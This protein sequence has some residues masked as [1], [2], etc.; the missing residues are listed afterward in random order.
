MPSFPRFLLWLPSAFIF[1]TG[2]LPAAPAWEV[3]P[4]PAWVDRIEPPLPELEKDGRFGEG[5]RY[6]LTDRQVLLSPEEAYSHLARQIVEPGGLSSGS[7]IRIDFDPAYEELLIHS[8]RVYR[9]GAWQSRLEGMD[10]LML[11]R[12]TEM[13]RQILDGSYTA[14]LSPRDIRTGDVLSYEYTLRG[15]NPVLGGKFSGRFWMGWSQPLDRLRLRF[16]VPDG[17]S[18]Q[19]KPSQPDLEPNVSSGKNGTEYA[20]DLADRP[21]ILREDG[22]PA[23]RTPYPFIEA[24]AYESWSGVVDW[25]L[26]LYQVEETLPPELQA[27][28]DMVAGEEDPAVRA[29]TILDWTRER[30]RYLGFL[31]GESSHRPKSTQ[32]TVE[33]GYGDCKAMALLVCSMLR[34]SGIEAAPVLVD[35]SGG[36]MVQQRI[37]SPGAFDHVIVEMKIGQRVYYVD[38]TDNR[39]RGPIEKRYL[40][41]FGYGLVVRSG[42][43]ALQRLTTPKES[44]PRLKVTERYTIPDFDGPGQL[45]VETMAYGGEADRLRSLF[46]HNSHEQIS[47]DYHEFQARNFPDIELLRSVE[48]EDFPEENRIRLVEHYRLPKPWGKGRSREDKEFEFYPREAHSWVPIEPGGSRTAHLEINHPVDNQ[49]T[50]VLE[51]PESWEIDPKPIEVENAV[52]SYRETGK[53]EGRTVT[54][55]HT[56]RSKAHEISPD[57]FAQ[58]R[59]DVRKVG[60]IIGYRFTPGLRG[61]EGILI[62]YVGLIGMTTAIGLGLVAWWLGRR[63][64]PLPPLSGQA[65]L[66]GIGGWLILVAIGTWLRPVAIVAITVQTWSQLGSGD[67][68]TQALREIMNAPKALLYQFI[69]M[70]ESFL[71]FFLLGLAIMAI[72]MLLLKSRWFPALTIFLIAT[73]AIWRIARQTIVPLTFQEMELGTNLA[74]IVGP[75]LHAA[76]WIPYLLLSK[77]VHATFR[78]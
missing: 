53:S 15:S 45:Q 59:R 28:V 25:A 69:L 6:L 8:V 56:Y 18:L 37:P 40:P 65:H 11:R 17:I 42:E 64:P 75:A 2:D 31:D 27:V 76:I 72:V 9:D 33:Q 62:Y 20:W 66:D 74:W 24:S 70:G 34:A 77:R 1:A 12:E 57:Q 32:F 67:T 4:V 10:V 19:I 52:F 47:A 71:L 49:L 14:T 68:S 54:F 39:Q 48:F 7:Q 51:L 21:G 5:V 16:L 63:Q 26:P 61:W 55:H 23:W 3:A 78:R 43:G 22:T 35:S 38:P 73:M 41:N 13:E 29:R 44:L 46:T 30:I 60:D 50:A 36:E 58:I